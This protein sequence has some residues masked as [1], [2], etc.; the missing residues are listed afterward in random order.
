MKNI[1]ICSYVRLYT[2]LKAVFLHVQHNIFYLEY[3]P[4]ILV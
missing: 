2:G 4:S 3:T 1:V